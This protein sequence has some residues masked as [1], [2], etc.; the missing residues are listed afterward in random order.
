VIIEVKK[1]IVDVRLGIVAHG[2]NASGGFGSGVAGAIKQKYPKVA[3][4]HAARGVGQ[5][6]LGNI[7]VISIDHNLQIINC[8]T[9]LNYGSDGKRY[10]DLSAIE[11]CLYKVISLAYSQ[12]L[13][14][15]IPKIGCGLGGLDYDTEVRPL[16]ERLVSAAPEVDIY[17]CDIN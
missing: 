17:V 7:D 14:V 13:P 2:C 4:A 5:H 8:Y 15:Y 6:L 16:L 11:S 1:N 12:G 3:E 9:Q 10:A